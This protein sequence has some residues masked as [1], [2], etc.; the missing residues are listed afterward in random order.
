LVDRRFSLKDEPSKNLFARLT[1]ADALLVAEREGARLIASEEVELQRKE[2]FQ[3]V[4]FLGTPSAEVDII[5][6]ERHDS[7]VWRQL[8]TWDGQKAVCGAGKHWID[9]APPGLSRLKGWDKDGAGPGLLWWQ[10]DMVAHNR[11]HH[12]DGTTTILA[13]GPGGTAKRSRPVLRLGSSG[14]DVEAWQRA[15]SA[16]VDGKFG[17]VTQAMTVAWQRRR[18]L[19]PDGVVGPKTWA[20]LDRESVDR[21]D[22]DQAFG[23]DRPKVDP[24]RVVEPAG[25]RLPAVKTPVSVKEMF[26]AFSKAVPE[27]SRDSLLVLLAQWSLETA[28]GKAIWAFNLGNAKATKSWKGDFCFF[29]CNEVIPYA[30]AQELASKS[31]PREPRRPEDD[32]AAFGPARFDKVLGQV[33]LDGRRSDGTTIAWFFPGHPYAC[34]RAHRSLDEGVAAHFELMRT[35]FASA[36][37][38]VVAGDV[39]Q[40]GSL[41]KRAGYYTAPERTPAKTGYVDGLE[42]LFAQ[43]K[44]RL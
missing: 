14:P 39:A 23:L 8:E 27:L 44:K 10:P 9:G 42:R 24:P 17:P 3:L 19:V 15:V 22:A 29:A 4:P 38:A 36:W 11:H 31:G 1:Y 5:H 7:N 2:G 20:A 43:L 26:D 30:H 13:R 40:F 34:F 35:R 28:G 16:S 6:S 21:V 25:R 32:P 37:S 12:D 33:T 41:L 18:N